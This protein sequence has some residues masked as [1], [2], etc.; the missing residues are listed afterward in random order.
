M[1]RVHSS[2]YF[3]YEESTACSI[4]SYTA[5]PFYLVFLSTGTF[6]HTRNSLAKAAVTFNFCE[7][8]DA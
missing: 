2:A 5:I 6:N 7:A 4:Q 1:S 8:T 3:G